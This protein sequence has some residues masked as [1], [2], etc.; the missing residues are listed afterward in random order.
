[1]R[2]I[3][4][5]SLAL[6][7]L[8]TGLSLASDSQFFG[9]L[10]MPRLISP[11]DNEDITGKETVEFRWSNEG[12][13]ANTRYYDFRLYEGSQAIEDRLILKSQVLAGE[14][15]VHVKANIFEDE[16][17]YAWSLRQVG[18]QKSRRAYSVFKVIKGA[19]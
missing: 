14:T 11:G 17:T 18:A 9:K 12:D 1:M 19:K 6:L 2:K 7:I 10:P 3:L 4:S 16:G 13:R 8:G 15:S 5:V